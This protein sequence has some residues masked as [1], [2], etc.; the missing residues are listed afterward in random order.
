VRFERRTGGERLAERGDCRTSQLFEFL[1]GF[2]TNGKRVGVELPD[3]LRGTPGQG[4]VGNGNRQEPRLQKGHREVARDYQL[5]DR[6]IGQISVG[7]IQFLPACLQL[8]GG[9]RL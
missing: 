1:G 6:F 3:K 2:V 7:A 9:Q 5:T 8:G 4:G